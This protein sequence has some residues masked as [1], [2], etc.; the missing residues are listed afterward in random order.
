MKQLTGLI[1]FILFVSIAS[2]QGTMELEDRLFVVNEKRVEKIDEYLD[3][4]VFINNLD[5]EEQELFYW[6]NVLRA[7][8]GLFLEKYVRPF[9][10]QFPEARGGASRSLI[11]DLKNQPS[12]PLMEPRKDLS[13]I[14]RKHTRDLAIN[15]N[16]I[17]HS[18]SDGKS[19]AQ[20]MA[21]EG[22]TCAGENILI[23]KSDA[24]KAIILL[25][26]DE[27]V[28][29]RGHRKALL[30]SG[31]NLIGVSIYPRKDGQ[32]ILDQLFSCK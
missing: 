6:V 24:L 7:N 4:F 9:L 22:I 25:L 19:F 32:Y 18:S 5:K 27:G 28:A 14:S 26:I 3:Q 30:N 23:G 1:V 15:T 20:R 29:N 13:D 17:S 2:G 12:L 11:S 16:G 31:F 10:E 8:P 21:A